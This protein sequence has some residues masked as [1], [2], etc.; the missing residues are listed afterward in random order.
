MRDEKECSVCHTHQPLANFTVNNALK[1]GVSSFCKSC[2]SLRR[3]NHY[4]KNRSNIL[5]LKKGTRERTKEQ[6]KSYQ[7]NFYYSNLERERT[8][9]KNWRSKNKEKVKKYNKEYQE[10]NFEKITKRQK[11]YRKNNP[12]KIRQIKANYTKN[13]P[14]AVQRHRMTR[15]ARKAQNGVFK[16][17][18]KELTK[19]MNSPCSNCGSTNRITIDHIIP[20]AKG[21]RHSVGNLQ[22]LCK[23]CNS[24]KGTKTMSKWKN[25]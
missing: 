6:R 7:Q 13:N 4:K 17:S 1:S 19:L 16:V 22:P 14:E 23:P 9:A 12:E 20:I 21:G 11:D 5:E 2:A 10:N 25:S 15:R 24:S 3:K 18:D 8:R